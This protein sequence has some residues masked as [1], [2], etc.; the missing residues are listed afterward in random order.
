MSVLRLVGGLHANGYI[1]YINSVT[2]HML[3]RNLKIDC[4]VISFH[5]PSC[6][7]SV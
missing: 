1:S 6:M 3:T 2:Q 5:L 4:L 7:D